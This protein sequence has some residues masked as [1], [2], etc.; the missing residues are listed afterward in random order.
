MNFE[1]YFW[2]FKCKYMIS[3]QDAFTILQ[4]NLPALQQVEYP[5][6]QARKHILAEDVFSPINMPPF[7]QSAMDGY[8]L[9]LFDGL[10]YEIL[11]EIKAGD[12]DLVELSPGQAIKIFTGA[13]VPDSAQAVIPIEKVSEKEGRLLLEQAVLP[14]TNVRPIGFR[15]WNFA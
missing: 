4:N 8:A 10:E 12:S 7:R 15:K 14:E 6:I 13:P 11:G 9:C 2:V 3:V 1:L 5:L